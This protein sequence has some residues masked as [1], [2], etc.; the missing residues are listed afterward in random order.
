[1]KKI[2]N[3]PPCPS[4]QGPLTPRVY[5]CEPCGVRLEGSFEAN[6]FAALPA[7]LLHVLRIF[8][9]CEGSLKEMEKALGVSYPTVKAQLA[10]LRGTLAAPAATASPAA[11]ASAKAPSP[12]EILAALQAGELDVN[13]A[14]TRLKRARRSKD[15]AGEGDET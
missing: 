12:K 7:D 11:A 8:V 10:R 9:H 15:A 1:M 6:E 3:I 5:A 4:C 13:E 14:L 2:K